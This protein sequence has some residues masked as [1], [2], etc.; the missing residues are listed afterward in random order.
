MSGRQLLRRPS[1]FFKNQNSF[2]NQ[3][4]WFSARDLV[5]PSLSY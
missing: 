3:S 5:C 2:P 4:A 1:V